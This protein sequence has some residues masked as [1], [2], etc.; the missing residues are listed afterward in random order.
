[1]CTH[2]HGHHAGL[3]ARVAARSEVHILCHPMA[4]HA[5]LQ[6]EDAALATR[7][8]LRRVGHAAAVPQPLVLA[9]I[10]AI[11][12]VSS[13]PAGPAMVSCLDNG[14]RLMLGGRK[15]K[16]LHTPGHSPDHIGLFEPRSGSF[17]GGDLLVR[18][19]PTR[20]VLDGVGPAFAGDRRL[21]ALRTSWRL[22]G[23]LP[24]RRLWP[25]H[26]PPSRAHRLLVARRLANLRRRLQEARRSVAD[27]AITVWDVIEAAAEAPP[28]A[29]LSAVLGDTVARLEWLC[30][31]GHLTRTAR[32]G[33]AC[34]NLHRRPAS[35]RGSRPA[36]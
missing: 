18:G 16:V 10:E 5:L 1:M 9:A 36:P 28:P 7:E 12:P 8:R 21:E 31:H 3:A 34:Y 30:R 33:H 14:K 6:P 25:S 26:G 4:A 23:R 24:V 13:Q 29:A 35:A 11:G 20:T 15:W 22:V 27:G 32:G 2:A 19:R 17:L